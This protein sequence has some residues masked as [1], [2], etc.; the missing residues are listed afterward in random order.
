MRHRSSTQTIEIL[1]IIEIALHYARSW[2][3]LA[4]NESHVNKQSH[5]GKYS[6]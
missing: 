3:E 2:R 4:E 6:S 5:R 1:E